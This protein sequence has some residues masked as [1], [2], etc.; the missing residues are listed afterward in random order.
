MAFPN[1]EERTLI[2]LRDQ[3]PA[4]VQDSNGNTYDILGHPVNSDVEPI[5]LPAQ[6][7]GYWVSWGAFYPNIDLF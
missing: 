2:P 7:I 5:K 4:I 1:S 3:L 6:F